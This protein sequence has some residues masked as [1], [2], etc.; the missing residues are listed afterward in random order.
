MRGFAAETVSALSNI[1]L[2]FYRATMKK[3]STRRTARGICQ[4]SQVKIHYKTRRT[5]LYIDYEKII[6]Y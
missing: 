3:V 5:V 4:K 1:L 6:T 2:T